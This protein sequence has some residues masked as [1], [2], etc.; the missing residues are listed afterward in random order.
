M[1]VSLIVPVYQGAQY[2]QIFIE[3]LLSPTELFIEVLFIHNRNP[4]KEILEAILSRTQSPSNI[5]FINLEYNDKPSSYAA[6]NYGVKMAR[7]NIVAFTDIDCI[8][9]KDY[10][11]SLNDWIKKFHNFNFPVISGKV[12]VFSANKSDD[13]KIDSSLFLNTDEMSKKSLGVTANLVASKHYL[14]ENPF[15]ETKSGGDV[16]WFK[17]LAC[18]DCFF[19]DESLLVNHPSRDYTELRTKVIRVSKGVV[20]AGLSKG[21]FFESL[22]FLFF[23]YNRK[24]IK[25]GHYK[26]GLHARVLRLWQLYCANILRELWIKQ[27]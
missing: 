7:N 13:F 5:T 15:P 23:S 10:F 22:R 21:F 4:D 12:K 1:S 25:N 3:S 20:E 11:V 16:K 9:T 2:Y 26:L 6:R 19:Y 17:S 24:L 27:F 8:I 18:R 14:L